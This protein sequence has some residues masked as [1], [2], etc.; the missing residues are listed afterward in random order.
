MV[1]CFNIKRL[2]KWQ[3]AGKRQIIFAIIKWNKRLNKHKKTPE[4][5]N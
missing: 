5:E 3:T 1:K 4:I 2:L